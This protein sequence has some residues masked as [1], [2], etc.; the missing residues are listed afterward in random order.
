MTDVNFNAGSGEKQR[1]RFLEEDEED[2]NVLDSTLAHLEKI[3]ADA[4]PKQ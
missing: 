1:Q 2:G 3:V 4:R